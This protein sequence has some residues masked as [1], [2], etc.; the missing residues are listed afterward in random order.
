[1]ALPKLETVFGYELQF[2]INHIGHFMLV[3]VCSTA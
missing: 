2:F 3:T 1:M